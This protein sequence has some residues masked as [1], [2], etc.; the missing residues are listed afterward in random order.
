VS[1]VVARS[2]IV[3]L[4][5]YT[6]DAKLVGTVK[7]IGFDLKEPSKLHILVDVGGGSLVEMPLSSVA[8]VGD[9][10]LLREGV[11]VPPPTPSPAPPAGEG[12]KEYVIPRCPK[13]GAALVY[14]PKYRRWYCLKC[15]RYVS[16]PKEVLE[17]VP[18]CPTCGNPLSYIEQYG[19]WYCYNCG[20]YV[21]V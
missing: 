20:K 19:K 11:E 4:K 16:V 21:E 13:C 6:H 5:V 10:V 1:S 7:D 14:Y 2:K 3:G 15:R 9:I 12:R 17:K 8:A 18:R